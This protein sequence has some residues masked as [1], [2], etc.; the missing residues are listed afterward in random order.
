MGELKIKCGVYESMVGAC[1]SKHY[2]DASTTR[3]GRLTVPLQNGGI[4]VHYQG[5]AVYVSRDGAD[6]IEQWRSQNMGPTF[7]TEV[8]EDSLFGDWL[9]GRTE[10][11]VVQR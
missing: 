1:S 4:P 5:Q 9:H 3:A 11:D 8:M 2:V 7:G 10:E 6:L